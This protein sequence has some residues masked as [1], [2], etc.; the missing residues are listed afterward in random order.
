MPPKDNKSSMP[1]DSAQQLFEE[2]EDDVTL[3]L[4]SLKAKKD[5]MIREMSGEDA[6]KNKVNAKVYLNRFNKLQDTLDENYGSLRRKCIELI[7]PRGVM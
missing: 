6:A 2:I 4:D 5:S 3:A 1:T 7:E